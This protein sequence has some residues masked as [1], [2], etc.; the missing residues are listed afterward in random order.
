[1]KKRILALILALAM[2]TALAACSGEAKD[3]GKTPE[4][5]TGEAPASEMKTVKAGLVCIGD[6]NDKGYTYNFIRATETAKAELAQKGINVEWVIKYNLIEGDPVAVANEELAEDGCAVIFNNSYGQEPAML[7]STFSSVA[8]SMP[9]W[10]SATTSI[11]NSCRLVSS[12]LTR[13]STVSLTTTIT[14]RR[15]VS[16]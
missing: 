5:E 2:V 13:V 3:T 9:P 7:R 4:S 8:L 11:T 6:E 15:W 1:M 10:W 14:S 16:M 12:S